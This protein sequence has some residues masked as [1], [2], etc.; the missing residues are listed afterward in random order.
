[1]MK[2]R[3]EIFQFWKWSADAKLT[4]MVIIAS[5]LYSLVVFMP[6]RYFPFHWDGAGFFNNAV[7]N[8]IRTNFSPLIASES[9]FAHPPL[10]QAIFAMAFVTWGRSMILAHALMFPFLPMLMVASFFLTKKLV[11]PLAGVI[12]VF[13][14]ATTPV[15]LAE[16]GVVYID[17][18]AAALSTTAM[19]LYVYKHGLSAGV[20]LTLAVMTKFTVILTI[21][22]YLGLAI[23]RIQ[24]KWIVDVRRLMLTLLAPLG[25]FAVWIVYHYRV[26]GWWLTIPQREFNNPT[27]LGELWSSLAQVT[28]QALVAQGRWSIFLAALIVLG[29]CVYQKKMPIGMRSSELISLTATLLTAIGFFTVTREFA[30]RYGIFMYPIYYTLMLMIMERGLAVLQ[31]KKTEMIMTVIGVGVVV[32]FISQWRSV[33]LSENEYHFNPPG[34]LRYEDM[35]TVFRQAAL[36]IQL[37]HS[38]SQVYGA[39]PENVYSTQLYQGYVTQPQDFSLCSEFEFDPNREQ[40]IYLHPYSPVQQICRSILDQIESTPLQRFEAGSHWIELH[41]VT[42]ATD[43]ARL[44]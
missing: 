13:M 36:Y 5:V 9:D 38:D 41:T 16:Y 1:M 23:A 26:T 35:I 40:I 3:P 6:T 11:S 30:L 14:V 34:D 44:K 33:P 15:I 20:F 43:S 28:S 29:M 8:L 22:F 32:V 4:L 12:S 25:V 27:S 21:P 39:F 24:S 19:A 17:L 2:M 31:P 7:E 10:L 18:P 42:R 37:K